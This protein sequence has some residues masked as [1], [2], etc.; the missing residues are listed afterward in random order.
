LSREPE[1]SPKNERDESEPLWKIC[2]KRVNVCRGCLD[3]DHLPRREKLNGS[4]GNATGT[5][6]YFKTHQPFGAP[7]CRM[8]GSKPRRHPSRQLLALAGSAAA[9]AIPPSLAH[10]CGRR[11]SWQW[12]APGWSVRTSAA[13]PTVVAGGGFEHRYPAFGCLVEELKARSRRRRIFFLGIRR[14]KRKTALISTCQER[15]IFPKCT[16][17]GYSATS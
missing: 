7:G 13:F 17:K 5:L 9:G 6:S 15:Y 1:A 14:Q 11:A 16:I 3:P 10:A 2:Q 4:C 12:L 8:G